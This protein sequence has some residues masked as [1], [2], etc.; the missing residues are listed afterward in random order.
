MVW[1]LTDSISRR[2]WLDHLSEGEVAS[3]SEWSVDQL[4]SIA[5]ILPRVIQGCISHLD[6]KSTAACS[7]CAV[8]TQL[9]DPDP[10]VYR[11]CS[12]TDKSVHDINVMNEIQDLKCSTY[13]RP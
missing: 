5:L 8:V 10:V 1:L 9:L 7:A 3:I 12:L 2:V 13:M 6:Y 11:S 4:G